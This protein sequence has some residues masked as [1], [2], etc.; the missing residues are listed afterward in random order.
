MNNKEKN[1]QKHYQL[2]VSDEQWVKRQLINK[3]I[4]EKCYTSDTLTECSLGK[5]PNPYSQ[6]IFRAGSS[7]NNNQQTNIATST[8]GL[9]N[10]APSQTIPN[11]QTIPVARQNY[12]SKFKLNAKVPPSASSDNLPSATDVGK[13]TQIPQQEAETQAKKKVTNNWQ[14]KVRQRNPKSEIPPA[15]LKNMG[16]FTLSANVRP[17]DNPKSQSVTGVKRKRDAKQPTPQP[18]IKQ[19]KT[20]GQSIPIDKQNSEHVN[21]SNVSMIHVQDLRKEERPAP[22]REKALARVPLAKVYNNQSHNVTQQPAHI[23][24]AMTH[25]QQ[26]SFHKLPNGKE[27]TPVDLTKLRERFLEN[28]PIPFKS[29]QVTFTIPRLSNDQVAI[30][31]PSRETFPNQQASTNP[32]VPADRQISNVTNRH[33][34]RSNVLVNQWNSG[35]VDIKRLSDKFLSLAATNTTLARSG[36]DLSS[37]RDSDVA[38][39]QAEPTNPT[40]SNKR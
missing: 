34:N 2:R 28:P 11:Q 9:N 40:I 26:T 29:T 23:Q 38:P 33:V 36:L 30:Q 6:K 16:K 27:G 10:E 21:N 1:S 17:L 7:N 35:P 15:Q 5:K 39:S 13:K 37:K 32:I 12:M 14:T 24:P 31:N 25:S 3:D 18:K 19:Q 22:K 20:T 8:R 4:G